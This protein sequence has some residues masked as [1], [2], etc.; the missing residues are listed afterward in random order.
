[1][2]GIKLDAITPNEHGK[3]RERCLLFTALRITAGWEHRER[4]NSMSTASIVQAAYRREFK[5]ATM[6]NSRIG[7]YRG[8]D[9]YNSLINRTFAPN[10]LNLIGRLI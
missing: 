7:S 8:T 9:T 1:M 4:Q 10:S 6:D 2:P 3:Y 5:V